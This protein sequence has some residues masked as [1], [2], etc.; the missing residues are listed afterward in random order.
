MTPEEKISEIDAKK[1]QEELLNLILQQPSHTS[2]RFEKIG[3][4]NNWT[5]NEHDYMKREIEKAKKEKKLIF[6]V[7]NHSNEN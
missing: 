2:L 1:E 4:Y 3:T 7:E 5:K 6:V